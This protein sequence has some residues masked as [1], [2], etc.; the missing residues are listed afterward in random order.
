MMITNIIILFLI[1]L[2]PLFEL[3]ASIPVGI[4]GG[5]I[6]LPLD[7]TMSGMG[8]PWPIVFLICVLSN[9]VLG[10]VIYPL[11]D[12]M[13]KLL[14]KN[15]FINNIWQKFVV[16][17][18]KRVH[19]YVEKWGTLGVALFIAVPL[20]GSGSYSGALG[21]YVLGVSYKHYIWANMLGVTIA[22]ILVTIITVTGRGIFNLVNGS[23]F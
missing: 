18:Q 5:T 1:T 8:L 3:R 2:L 19:P 7:L 11:V 4:L 12:L 22:G 21:A 15:H 14:E 23:V 9:M 20:P 16:R 13:F 17:S 10:F 6:H